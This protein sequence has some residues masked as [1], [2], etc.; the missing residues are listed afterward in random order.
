MLFDKSTDMR[1]IRLFLSAL[2]N[3]LRLANGKFVHKGGIK[4]VGNTNRTRNSS[5]TATHRT[6]ISGSTENSQRKP[7]NLQSKWTP[8]IAI[9]Q[10]SVR[11]RRRI[12]I[13]VFVRGK[14]E[15]QFLFSL[16]QFIHQHRRVVAWD[17]V[18][19]NLR[20][21]E[22]FGYGDPQDW[23]YFMPRE[24]TDLRFAEATMDDFFVI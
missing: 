2:R 4:L 23:T 15:R 10:A 13:R 16:E 11:D 9:S 18:L 17:N 24:K 20:G 21:K 6:R 5:S 14:K 3:H 12:Q 19:S 8:R 22:T 1:I 7:L